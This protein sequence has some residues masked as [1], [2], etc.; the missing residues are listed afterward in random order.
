MVRVAVAFAGGTLSLLSPCSALLLPSFFA[1][2]FASPGR[3]LARTLIF[4]AGLL[5]LF[6]PLGLGAGA[7]GSTIRGHVTTAAA[8]AGAILIVI[9]VY[10]LATGGF[11]LPGAGRLSKHVSG[12]S[13]LATYALGLTY[14]VGGFCSGPI[15]AGILTLAATSGHAVAGGALL[16]VFALGMVV[17]VIVLALAWDRIGQRRKRALRGRSVRIGR[18]ERHWSTI[19]SSLIFIVLGA[20]FIVFRGANALSGLYEKA[21]ASDLVLRLEE[22]VRR[23]GSGIAIILGAIVAAV[24]LIGL[25]RAQSVRRLARAA[26]RSA[27]PDVEQAPRP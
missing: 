11:A 3:M 13:A 18:I 20:A 16:A 22:S 26:R 1:Y 9:G 7:L 24:I 25:S 5:T 19:A 15:L 23:H 6:V 2:A 4:Y 21:G 17:P 27:A 14:G 12:E 10:Q 8:I